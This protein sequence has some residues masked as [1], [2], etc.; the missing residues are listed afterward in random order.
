MKK[1]LR[2]VFRVGLVLLFVA[3]MA[4]P[5]SAD[6]LFT[7]YLGINFAGA[8][9]SVDLADLRE[10]FDERINFGGS[11]AG[12]GAGIFGFE[13][14]FNYTPNFFQITEGGEVT[15]LIDVNSSM[16][17]FMGN[18]I[19]GIPL[20]GTSGFGIRPYLAGGIG[21]MRANIEF[22]DLFENLS[23]ND[24]ALNV[25]G[26]INMFFSDS[27]GIRGDLRYFR[28]LAQESDDP[29]TDEDFIDSDFGLVDFDYWR[30]TVGVTFRF[31]S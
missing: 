15:D 5:A 6:W 19:L 17:T 25:G 26:G 18:L 31:G 12:M 13:V 14:D 16:T 21:L 10:D 2:Q 30:A 24:L 7:P 20:G 4:R 1:G 11:L 28:D 3:G 8:A 22:D 23:T 27:V 9:N 29:L